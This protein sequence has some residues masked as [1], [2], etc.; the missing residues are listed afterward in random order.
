M[1]ELEK[2]VRRAEKAIESE[3]D[4]GKKPD[5]KKKKS[6]FSRIKNAAKKMGKKLKGGLKKLFLRLKAV[7]KRV[8]AL[9]QKAKAKITR[10]VLGILG[11]TE[12]I[13]A[14][15]E[16]VK[17][18]KDKQIPQDIESIDTQTKTMDAI[19]EKI[20]ELD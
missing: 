19:K 20:G 4:P 17:D 11:L 13:A 10:V 8:K 9:I 18:Q 7:F 6:F 2:E 1:K 15:H 5:L 12:D 3:K 14:G 16:E